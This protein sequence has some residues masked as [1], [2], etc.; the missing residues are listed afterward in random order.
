[1]TSKWGASNKAWDENWDYNYKKALDEYNQRVADKINEYYKPRDYGKYYFR[2]DDRDQEYN[3]IVNKLQNADT[4]AM[5]NYLDTNFAGLGGSNMWLNNYWNGNELND[6]TNTFIANN[7]NDALAQL[8]RAKG[9]GYLSAGGYNNALNN[10]NNQM[11]G[12]KATVGDIGKG[13]LDDYRADLT[14][15]AQGYMTDLD[16]YN[17]NRYDT[18][19]ADKWQQDFNDLYNQQQQGLESKFNLA[20]NGLNLFDTSDLIGNARLSQGVTNNQSDELY[21]AI[22]EQN[23]KKSKKVGLG[24]VGLF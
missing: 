4:K 5:Q 24:N 11:S 8:E 15:K 21:N 9:R 6:L 10:L 19:N 14:N 22:D 20:T 17:L 18:I 3:D 23:Q 7:Y 16:N 1:M 13:I 2:H 12:A